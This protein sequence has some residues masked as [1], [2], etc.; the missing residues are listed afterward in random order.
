MTDGLLA[1]NLQSES[2]ECGA[3]ALTNIRIT[4]S[5]R[6]IFKH[7]LKKYGVTQWIGFVWLSFMFGMEQLLKQQCNIGLRTSWVIF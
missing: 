7:I 2:T 5:V 6:M 4:C 3:R 1:D